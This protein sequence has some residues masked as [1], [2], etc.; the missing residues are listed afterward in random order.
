MTRPIAGEQADTAGLFQQ[1]RVA[2]QADR[3]RWDADWIAEQRFANDVISGGDARRAAERSSPGPAHAP[4]SREEPRLVEQE[5]QSPHAST[6]RGASDEIGRATHASRDSAAQPTAQSPESAAV[7]SP[8]PTAGRRP[9]AADVPIVGPATSSAAS[10]R[11]TRSQFAMWR[12]DDAVRVAMRLRKPTSDADGIVA[13]LRS[14]LREAG[15]TLMQVIV[16]GR[17]HGR[18]PAQPGEG[19]QPDSSSSLNTRI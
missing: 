10:I 14:W 17:S 7:G 8:V 12:S 15:L 9:R 6:E 19:A 2:T 4:A 11:A 3:R 5:Q 13:T 16:N 18:S 1:Q